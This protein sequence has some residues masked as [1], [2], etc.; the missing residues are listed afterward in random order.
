L[1]CLT[2][3]SR[4]IPGG[5]SSANAFF[6]QLEVRFSQ[7]SLK[8]ESHYYPH[9]LPMAGMGST[10]AGFKE[11]KRR[12]QSN[13]YNKDLNLNW[14]DFHAKQYDPQ[15]GRFLGVDP[16]ADAEGQ[17]GVEPVCCVNGA[18]LTRI[19]T[20]KAVKCILLQTITQH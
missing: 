8:E 12:Y 1:T 19:V 3:S 10:A 11:N 18:A 17:T 15:L 6:D 5:V 7:G 2:N 9:G 14:M 13:D 16:L 4:V 20:G